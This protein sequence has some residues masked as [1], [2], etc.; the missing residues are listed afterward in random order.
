MVILSS[1]SRLH[2]GILP[3]HSGGE[4][5]GTL[6]SSLCLQKALGEK[7]ESL[8]KCCLFFLCGNNG[9][10]FKFNTELKLVVA[11]K[12]SLITS[13]IKNVTDRA[14]IKLC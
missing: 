13:L 4:E 11:F 10:L 7:K 9:S 8:L 12:G 3:T 5:A 14:S 1:F 2:R 6:S